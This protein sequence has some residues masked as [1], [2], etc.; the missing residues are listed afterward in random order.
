[1]ISF[2]GGGTENLL[3][4]QWREQE[5]I[6]LTDWRVE[7]GDDEIGIRVRR[8][9]FGHEFRGCGIAAVLLGV[10]HD[11]ISKTMLV[12]DGNHRKMALVSN[13]AGER[14][15]VGDDEIDLGVVNE[16]VELV[17]ALPRMRNGCE[18]LGDRPFVT[19]TVVDVGEAESVDLGDVE[20]ILEILE[21]AV[22]GGY[23]DFMAVGGEVG[24]DFLGAG[25][26]AGAFT[27]DSVEDVGHW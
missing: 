23:V 1:M 7:E 9:Q 14:L 27:V 24:E 17:Q 8:H 16:G 12:V 4:Q 2:G 6:A 13:V 21:A 5:C 11:G 25:G 20:L 19:D 18:I 10:G 22:E 3:A 15:E 26:V